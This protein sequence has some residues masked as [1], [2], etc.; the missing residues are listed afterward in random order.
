MERRI[1]VG[2]IE[3]QD[4]FRR[5]DISQLSGNERVAMLI[6]MQSRY[7]RWDLHSK[8]EKVGRLKRKNFQDVP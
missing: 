4:D 7:L 2:K 6:Q 5:A 1:R 8:M 3:D